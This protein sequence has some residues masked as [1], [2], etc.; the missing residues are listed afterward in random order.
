MN[1]ENSKSPC[2]IF[3][4]LGET[5]P[6]HLWLNIRRTQSLFPSAEIH[7]VKDSNLKIPSAIRKSITIHEYSRTTEVEN[8]RH[9]HQ[10]DASFRQGFWWLSLE[11]IL[12][13]CQAHLASGRQHAI[14]IESDVILMP[15]FPWEMLSDSKIQWCR[16]NEVRDVAAILSLPST[17]HTEW[18]MSQIIKGIGFNLAHTD[19][20]LLSEISRSNDE[21]VKILPGLGTTEIDLRNPKNSFVLLKSMAPIANA[22]S[23]G[24]FDGAAIGMWL[25]GQDPKNHYGVTRFRNQ[26][27]IESGDSFVDPSRFAFSYTSKD[28]LKLIHGNS[29]LEVWNLHVHSKNIKLFGSEWEI[30]L[31]RILGMKGKYEEFDARILLRLLF[32]NLRQRSLLRYCLSFPPIYSRLKPLKDSIGKIH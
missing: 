12:A 7:F 18:L 21:M 13:I 5:V 30:E 6:K 15:N 24:I 29:S 2:V 14:H 26:S 28:G 3:A 9:L 19:M 23:K 31:L 25:C 20:T 4:H 22:E 8:M 11:R 1:Q 10:H 17:L 32:S 27:I 16:Y